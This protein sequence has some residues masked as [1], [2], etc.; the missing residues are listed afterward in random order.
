VNFNYHPC[1]LLLCCTTRI[2]ALR[3]SRDS[4]AWP[5]CNLVASQRR[6]YCASVKSH[7][8]LG[9]LSRQ[10]DAV[11]L[12]GVLCDRRIHNDGVSRSASLRQCSCPFY[13]SLADFLGKTSHY[14]G[15]SAPHTDHIWLPATSGFT[16]S[17]NRR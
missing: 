12:A 15:L 8:S 2:Q 7:S 6:P 10:G 13:S 11:D 16:Q 5:S 14:P 17:N 4:F 9:L 1:R 3:I